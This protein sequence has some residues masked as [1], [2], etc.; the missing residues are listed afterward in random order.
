MRKY[1]VVLISIIFSFLVSA[2]EKSNFVE[3]GTFKNKYQNKDTV[4][5]VIKSNFEGKMILQISLE[6]KIKK[7]WYEV[8]NDIFRQSEF[9]THENIIILNNKDKRVEKWVP[10]SVALGKKRLLGD[11]RFKFKFCDSSQ[12]INFTTYSTSFLLK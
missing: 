6:K 3:I 8:L 5:I 4:S 10:Y 12:D 2:Q 7:R 9:T 1:S 11:F